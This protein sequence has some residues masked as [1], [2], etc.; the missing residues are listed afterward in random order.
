[1]FSGAEAVGPLRA[2]RLVLAAI[3]GITD[4]PIAAFA[5]ARPED[6]PTGNL[7]DDTA[8]VIDPYLIPSREVMYTVRAEAKT[9]G[10]GLFVREAV[11]EL[12]GEP[13]R[14]F[15]VHAWRRGD[16]DEPGPELAGARGWRG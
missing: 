2:S 6:D 8:A 3:P 16:L 15:R 14:P 13:D 7:D 1:V 5:K 10:G 4:Q 9:A 12:T 11:V